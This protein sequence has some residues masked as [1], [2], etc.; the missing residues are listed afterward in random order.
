[1]ESSNLGHHSSIIFCANQL[2][3]LDLK[4]KIIEI[5]TLVLPVKCKMAKMLPFQMVS[6]DIKDLDYKQTLYILAMIDLFSNLHCYDALTSMRVS[7]DASIR[8]ATIGE[9]HCV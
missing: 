3:L 5:I 2:F 6:H 8:L 4:E 9:R 7:T 1:M